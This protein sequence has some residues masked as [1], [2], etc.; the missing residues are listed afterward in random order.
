MVLTKGKKSSSF[1][2]SMTLHR[3]FIVDDLKAPLAATSAASFPRQKVIL[4]TPDL[5]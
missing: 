2:F 4:V 1:C 3:S 5:Q